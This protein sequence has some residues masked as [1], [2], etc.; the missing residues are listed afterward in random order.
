VVHNFGRADEVDPEMLRRLAASILRVTGHDGGGLP[1]LSTGEAHVAI[2]GPASAWAGVAFE[3]DADGRVGDTSV[4]DQLAVDAKAER[5]TTTSGWHAHESRN[6]RI[7][8]TG[9]SFMSLVSGHWRT[10]TEIVIGDHPRHWTF[11]GVPPSATC[12]HVSQL[13]AHPRVRAGHCLRVGV[14]A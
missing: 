10:G 5:P 1:P 13:F 9:Q 3:F 11:V 2:D 14:L 12:P 4:F 8:R 7:R 6:Q